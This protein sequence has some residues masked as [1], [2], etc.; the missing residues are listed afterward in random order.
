MTDHEKNGHIGDDVYGIDW[1][2]PP[3]C[4]TPKYADA[5]KGQEGGYFLFGIVN[6]SDDGEQW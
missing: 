1:V 2:C 6:H 5:N 3:P 4:F